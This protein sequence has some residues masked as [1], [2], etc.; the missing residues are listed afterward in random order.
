MPFRSA[1]GMLYYRTDLLADIGAEP[2]ETFDRP[3]SPPQKQIQ[4]TETDVSYGYVWQG[5]QYE[6]LMTNFVEIMWR[7]TAAI[8][9]ESRHLRSRASTAP[10]QA[11]TPSSL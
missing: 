11:S 10:K 1:M 8:W 9:V 5:L 4:E 6:G 2:P 7:A 3:D